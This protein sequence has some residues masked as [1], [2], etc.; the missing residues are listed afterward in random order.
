MDLYLLKQVFAFL[1]VVFGLVALIAPKPLA[2]AVGLE[3]DNPLGIAEIR[4]GWGGLYLAFGVALLYMQSPSAY[5]IIGAGY[6]GMFFTR[7]VQ[8]LLNRK[9][10][11]PSLIGILAFELLTMLI[12]MLH[13]I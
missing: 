9:L 4:T 11:K 3:T 1:N 2:K 12:F 13:Q 7:L 10:F 6:G 5:W 8:L